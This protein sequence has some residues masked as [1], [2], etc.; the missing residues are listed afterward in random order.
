MK[1]PKIIQNEHA[2]AIHTYSRDGWQIHRKECPVGP[3]DFAFQFLQTWGRVSFL[4]T[5]GEGPEDQAKYEATLSTPKE[6]VDRAFEVA[7]IYMAEA[8]RR[9][10]VLA[11]TFD[12][13]PEAE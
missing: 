8:K 3:A 10:Y 5:M 6:L 2:A 1:N 4:P 7:E 11:L 9:G 12:N 13:E